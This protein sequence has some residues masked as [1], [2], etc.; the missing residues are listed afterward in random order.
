MNSRA[1]RGQRGSFLSVARRMEVTKHLLRREE[2]VRGGGR[3][4]KED[5]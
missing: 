2:L 4:F 3:C 1:T 5:R